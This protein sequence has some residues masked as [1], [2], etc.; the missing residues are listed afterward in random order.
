VSVPLYVAVTT[1]GLPTASAVVVEVQLYGV[2]AG[3]VEVAATSVP[4]V[5]VEH[6]I[7]VARPG[8]VNTTGPVGATLPAATGIVYTNVSVAP[9]VIVPGV[10]VKLWLNTGV[11]EFVTGALFTTSDPVVVMA[12]N[13]PLAG[14]VAVSGSLPTGRFEVVSVA[15]QEPPTRL[16][17]P[18]PS[19]VVPVE[20]V[21]G[22]AGQA[23]LIGANDSVN[24]TGVPYVL[25]LGFAVSVPEDTAAFTVT[26]C[27]SAGVFA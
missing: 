22:P 6:V 9:A 13:G 7:D 3:V 26:F 17:G 15:T 5:N 21:A 19:V 16:T 27:V 18:V 8:L 4:A 10:A 2:Y 12:A 25:G 20:N 23:L 1:S 24:V 14:T 11:T